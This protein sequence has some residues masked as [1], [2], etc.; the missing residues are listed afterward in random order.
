MSKG[1]PSYRHGPAPPA[2]VETIETVAE[3]VAP[4]VS[5]PEPE[6][7]FAAL[8]EHCNDLHEAEEQT[9]P[10]LA[11]VGQEAKRATFEGRIQQA[12]AL[13]ALEVRLTDLKGALADAIVIADV[14]LCADLKRLASI[15]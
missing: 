8:I 12:G 6:A 1:R 13:Y 9:L 4:V 3:P 14:A 15:L 7:P 10:L 2:P 5:R 11:F